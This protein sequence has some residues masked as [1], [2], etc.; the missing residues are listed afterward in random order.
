[1]WLW[2]LTAFLSVCVIVAGLIYLTSGPK[3]GVGSP[4]GPAASQADSPAPVIGTKAKRQVALEQ[5]EAIRAEENEALAKARLL[6]VAEVGDD[7]LAR[8]DELDAE[9][10]RWEKEIL[11]LET[12][13]RGKLLA[14]N[15]EDVAAY[16]KLT[17]IP[18]NVKRRAERFR[19]RADLLSKHLKGAVSENAE[20][21][22]SG[23]VVA[24]M[25]QLGQEVE[26]VIR[27][28]SEPRKALE[29]L[30]DKAEKAKVGTKLTIREAIKE[31]EDQA[32]NKRRQAKAELDAFERKER[33]RLERYAQDRPY[34]Q[35][36]WPLKFGLIITGDTNGDGV[37]DNPGRPELDWR[38]M[39][40]AFHQSK[41]TQERGEPGPYL[42]GAAPDEPFVREWLKVRQVVLKAPDLVHGSF[43]A[44]EDADPFSK[45]SMREA[46]FK[47]ALENVAGGFPNGNPNL[48][49]LWQGWI[50]KAAEEMK[51]E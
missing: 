50:R 13:E 33:Q 12:N 24:E 42:V 29:R 3:P 19:E 7:V 11:P 41:V 47:E 14:A 18:P 45:R 39:V 32:E 38:S 31:R 6:K 22:P 17:V 48:V 37:I 51:A 23:G 5:E 8:I 4:A 26:A 49:K 30:L 44:F 16:E 2:P 21:R 34:F 1:M 9:V 46:W 43:P 25:K 28:L 36:S 10:G 27:Q 15:A 40:V 35:K 20:A